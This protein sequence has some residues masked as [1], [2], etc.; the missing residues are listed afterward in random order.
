MQLSSI[1]FPS[2]ALSPQNTDTK[3]KNLNHFDQS[4][5]QQTFT[6]ESLEKRRQ[7]G[8]G[9]V[10][11]KKKHSKKRSQDL[12][13]TLR[14]VISPLG[15]SVSSS[16]KKGPAKPPCIVRELSHLSKASLLIASRSSSTLLLE[17][18]NLPPIPFVS[19]SLTPK[20]S[21]PF[22][23]TNSQTQKLPPLL[24]LRAPQLL[25]HLLVE[26]LCESSL[27][28]AGAVRLQ[29]PLSH[30]KEATKA[31]KDRKREVRGRSL[32]ETQRKRM[33]AQ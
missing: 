17:S 12:L 13:C 24:T 23:S 14:R 19:P 9:E 30:F 32:S 5:I 10:E 11:S 27:E 1:S 6:P 20:Y 26:G 18:L 29:A 22:I 31:R 28:T 25:A 16:V 33:E 15:A 21:V 3:G 2:L 4:V 8:G 7:I